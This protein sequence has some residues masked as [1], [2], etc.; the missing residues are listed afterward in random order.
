MN[1]KAESVLEYDKIKN[2]LMEYAVS[3]LAREKIASMSPSTDEDLLK[4]S[5]GK[6]AKGT[7]LLKAGI[8]LPLGGIKDIRNGL[9]LA[10]VGSMLSPGRTIGYG[11]CYEGLLV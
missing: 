4:H 8:K 1:K 10:K 7:A 11:I 5:K 3:L 2:I 6:P 9:R